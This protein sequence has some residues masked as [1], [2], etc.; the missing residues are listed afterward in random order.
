MTDKFQSKF[1]HS[2]CSSCHGFGHGYLCYSGLVIGLDQ[3]FGI[4]HTKN[5]TLFK[6]E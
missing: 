4:Y 3:F 1:W 2:E 6:S 5:D